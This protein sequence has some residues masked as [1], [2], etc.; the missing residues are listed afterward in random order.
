LVAYPKDGQIASEEWFFAGD[1]DLVCFAGAP[2]FQAGDCVR[3]L[4]LGPSEAGHENNHSAQGDPVHG[5]NNHSCDHRRTP[6]S[7]IGES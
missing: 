5:S 4:I 3:S 7:V 2:R 1:L 6:L